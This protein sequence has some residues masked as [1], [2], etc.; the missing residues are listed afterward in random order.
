MKHFFQLTIGAILLIGLTNS[1]KKGEED[2]LFS[3]HSRK[4]R[5]AGEWTLT[6]IEL[7]SKTVNGNT[8]VTTVTGYDGQTEVTSTTV[9]TSGTT[10]SSTVS[11][12]SYTQQMTF[13]KDG[14]YTQIRSENGELTTV[15][16]TWI[17]LKK[18]KENDLKN[19]EAI[20]LSE[21]SSTS[22][23]GTTTTDGVAGKVYIL[24]QL[25]NKE[26]IWKIYSSSTDA[27]NSQLTDGTWT[28]TQD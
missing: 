1:C 4:A 3:F 15:K 20:L 2:P 12:S 10:V 11:S 25:K 9:T 7:G 5:I 17:F 8:V 22:Q 21:T 19:K 27:D 28:L 26:M 23:Y 24:Q 18:S 14:T 13:E 6:N 16:G